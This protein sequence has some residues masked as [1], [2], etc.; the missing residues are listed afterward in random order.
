M[1][2]PLLPRLALALA[3]P[4]RDRRFALA[5]LQDE[6]EGRSERDGEALARRWYRQQA[7]QSLLPLLRLKLLGTRA[8]PDPSASGGGR[9]D[10]GEKM[11]DFLSDVRY[12]FRTLAQQPLVVVTTLLSLGIGIAAVT[13]IFTIANAFLLRPTTGD[14]EVLER[15]V[16]V[17]TSQEGGAANGANSFPDFQSMRDQVA[18]LGDDS[19]LTDLTTFRM[20]VVRLEEDEQIDTLMVEIT[21]GNYFEVLGIRPP[22]GRGFLPEETQMGSAEPVAVIAYHLWRDRFGAD[23]TMLGET[24]QLDGV[25]FTV[26][27]VAPEGLT[28]RLLSL[29]IDAWLPLGIPGGTYHATP[30]ELADRDDREYSIFGA[31]ADGATI[32]QASAQMDALAESLHAEYNDIW[33]DDLGRQRRI[34]VLSERDSRVPPDAR[35][36]L[37]GAAGLMLII[38]GSILFI[39]CA[40]VA[41]MFLARAS[42]RGREMAV[43]L[44]LG[45]SRRRLVRM[46][47]TESLMLGLASGALG[48]ALAHQAAKW[49]GSIPFPLGIALSFDFSLDYR[50]MLFALFISVATSVIFGLA[51]AL[52]ASKPSLVNAL[53]TLTGATGRRPGRFS[54]RNLL[55]VGQV[56]VSMVFLV[57]AGLVLRTIQIESAADT[58]INPERIASMTKWLDEEEYPGPAAAD[59]FDQIQARLTALPEVEAAHSSLTAELSLLSSVFRLQV[60]VDGFAQP[61][62]ER[63]MVP[64]NAVTPGY[65]EMLEIELL[66][67]RTIR[68]TDTEGARRVAV[69][70]EA[71]AERYWPDG[72][73]VGQEFRVVARRGAR[74]RMDVQPESIEIVGVVANGQYAGFE[75]ELT[76][77]VWLPI[78]QDYTPY[79]FLHVKGRDGYGAEVMASLMRREVPVARREVSLIQPTSYQELAGFQFVIFGAM[80]KAFGYAGVFALLLAAIGIYGIVSFSVSQRRHEMAV[81]QAVGANP[82]QVRNLVLRDGM[83]LA[84]SGLVIGLVLTVPLSILLASEIPDLHALDPFALGGSLAVLITTALIASLIPSRR[85]LRIDPMDTL[86]QE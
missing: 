27:G 57:S 10:V 22:L 39:A 47:L 79:R 78:A 18:S 76:P 29:K 23:P 34:T 30:T 60:E 25:D 73:A 77:F 64:H 32:E 67:G 81:R 59:Y 41:G 43:R 83:I 52:Q 71:F 17:Y 15:V 58:G 6:L 55:V 70:N 61:D 36:G 68:Q 82:D 44:S 14:P 35:P 69:V 13:S 20:G 28:G 4:R 33:E 56:A 63:T 45:A 37:Y 5:D 26:V 85:L 38:A 12:A 50:V 11:P 31:L 16:A 19:A 51:P 3:L 65:M 40:N 84:I 80:S 49:M 62:G 86:R 53:K 7:A 54:L 8:G 9:F 66:R 46:L 42:R 2:P 75:G 48:V 72:T 21:T 74:N 24:I 1:K